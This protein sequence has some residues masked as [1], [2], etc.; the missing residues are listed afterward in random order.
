MYQAVI[1]GKIVNLRNRDYERILDRLDVSKLDEWGERHVQCA[2]CTRLDMNCQ[3]CSFGQFASSSELT[4]CW[5]L[6]KKFFR[7]KRMK[8]LFHLGSYCVAA[9][10]QKQREQLRMLHDTFER[11]FRR[12]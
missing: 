11:S 8:P 6:V 7:S 9:Y 3:E 12:V 5:A 4:G 1:E 2:L 10:T